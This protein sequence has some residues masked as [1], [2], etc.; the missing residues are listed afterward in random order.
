MPACPQSK[1]K[2][3]IPAF[4]KGDSGQSLIAFIAAFR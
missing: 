2:G 3:L 4:T 1:E